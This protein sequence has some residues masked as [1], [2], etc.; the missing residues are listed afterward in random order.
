MSVSKKNQMKHPNENLMM[1]LMMNLKKNLELNHLEKNNLL[2]N[3]RQND[4][5]NVSQQVAKQVTVQPS[6]SQSSCVA[7]ILVKGIPWVGDGGVSSVS[8]SVV[9]SADDKND[10]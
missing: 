6:S 10:E 2:K 7:V 9:S 3:D 5:Q 1:P 8:L 4:R